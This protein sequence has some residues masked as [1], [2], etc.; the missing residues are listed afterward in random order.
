[1]GKSNDSK[2]PTQTY[3][4]LTEIWWVI[5]DGYAWCDT[6]KIRDY[7]T[8]KAFEELLMQCNWSIKTWNDETHRRRANK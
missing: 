4:K 7:L 5:H 2:I 1:M 8:S 6:K 3:E